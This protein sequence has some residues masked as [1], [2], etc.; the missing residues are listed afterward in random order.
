MLGTSPVTLRLSPFFHLPC[1]LYASFPRTI[2]VW[3]RS[4]VNILDIP[5]KE[6]PVVI[7]DLGVRLGRMSG[8]ALD[9]T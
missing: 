2:A 6:I 7:C 5:S 4:L 9:K 3:L 1:I 8:L